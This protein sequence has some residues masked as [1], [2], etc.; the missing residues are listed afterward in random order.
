MQLSP[1]QYITE[2]LVKKAH[3]RG[4]YLVSRVDIKPFADWEISLVYTTMATQYTR[5]SS[6]EQETRIKPKSTPKNG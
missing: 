2:I 1:S 4:K 6:H 3:Q 5:S